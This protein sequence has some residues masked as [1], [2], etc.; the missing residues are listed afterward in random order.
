MDEEYRVEV[1]LDDEEHGY[2]FRERLHALGLD[3]KM[4]ERLG[5][6][7]MVTRDG[8]QLFLYTESEA[9]AR[10]AERVVRSLVASEELTAEIRTT[11]W[12]D[13]EEAWRDVSIPVP[14]TEAEEA[15]A[16]AAREAAE[17]AEAAAEGEYDWNVVVRLPARST[18]RDLTRRLAAEGYPVMRRWRYVSIGAPTEEAADE[19]AA[20]LRSALAEETDVR[21]EVDLSDV[22]R[23]PLQFLP[24]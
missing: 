20:E 11:R 9:Q 22:A 21:V 23:S 13:V 14:T 6:G 17:E 4:R 16:Y 19:L 10:E 18:A 15:A 24:F 3:E 5:R 12:H 1:D 2:S 8:A 7:V